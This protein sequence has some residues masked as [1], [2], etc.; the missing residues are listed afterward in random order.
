MAILNGLYLH[1]TSESVSRGVDATSR[2]VEEGLPLV[3][4]VRPQALAIS[5]QGKI[6]DYGDVKAA[7]VISK[8]KSLQDSGSL[9]SYSGRNVSDN[10]QI[11][12][13]DSDHASNNNGGADFSIEMVKVR[14]AKSAYTP[15]KES[16]TEREEAEV[17]NPEI[18]V[19]SIVVFKGGPVYRSSD[20]KE[21]SA[22]R[23][24]ST[25][26]CTKISTKHYAIHQYHLISTDGG[27]VYGWVDKENIEGVVSTGTGSTTHAGTQQTQKKE[28]KETETTT[29]EQG[30][31][32]PVYHHVKKGEVVYGIC[33]KYQHLTP[34]PTVRSVY[35][36]NATCFEGSSTLKVGAYLLMGYEIR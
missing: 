15:K 22:T 33:Q 26:K 14:I 12:S 5:I 34:K 6:V 7:E 21:A 32:Y 23:G 3:D 13:F 24:R 19:G 2:P 20:R 16:D 4:T 28:N 29:N 18:T 1:V 8:L 10:L 36:N 30:T 35:A 25:C 9:I 11:R 27:K 31:K 17:K